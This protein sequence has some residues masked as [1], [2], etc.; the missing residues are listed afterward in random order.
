MIEPI[1]GGLVASVLVFLAVAAL[2]GSTAGVVA[3]LIL[4]AVGTAALVGMHILA[5][6]RRVAVSASAGARCAN[7]WP[8]QARVR[9]C[10]SPYRLRCSA[11]TAGRPGCCTGG[12]TDDRLPRR[13]RRDGPATWMLERQLKTRRSD[14]RAK[15]GRRGDQDSPVSRSRRHR[16]LDPVHG[17]TG[18]RP[19]SRAGGSG[20]RRAVALGQL[21]PRR[22]PVRARSCAVRGDRLSVVRRGAPRSRRRRRGQVFATVFLGSG[23][24]FVGH[25]VRRL[26]RCCGPRRERWAQR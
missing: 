25:A 4:G 24:L 21:T 17:R 2:F 8:P 3:V 26:G 10:T 13:R 23:L 9:Q 22:H 12:A 5:A 16:V 20:R 11:L 1:V 18:P 15:D 7:G 14:H 19:F 6:H